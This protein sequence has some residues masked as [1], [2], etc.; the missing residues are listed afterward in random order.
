LLPVVV[1]LSLFL[2]PA[3]AGSATEKDDEDDAMAKY[4]PIIK[5]D[6]I[7]LDTSKAVRVSN[8]PL[9]VEYL[10]LVL[11]D[12]LLYLSEAHEEGA[13][14]LMAYFVGKGR[15]KL[16]PPTEVDR[17]MLDYKVDSETLDTTFTEAF[18][19][20]F[21]GGLASS[22]V[23]RLEPVDASKGR[24]LQE[25]YED[26]R[27]SMSSIPFATP[28]MLGVP[29]RPEWGDQFAVNMKT[30]D[31]GWV[32]YVRDPSLPKENL[33]WKELNLG[34]G[35]TYFDENAENFWGWFEDQ[36]DLDAAARGEM[37]L[38]RD[39][40]DRLQMDHVE[41]DLTIAK[42]SLLVKEK[43]KVTF[44][45]LFDDETFAWFSLIWDNE[46]NHRRTKVLSVKENGEDKAFKH[47]N[48]ILLVGL[49]EPTKAG[50]KRTLELEA[51]FD[52]IRPVTYFGPVPPGASIPPN[53]DWLDQEFQTFT[54]LNTYPWFPQHGFLQRYS[55]DWTIRTPRPIIAV[56][57]GT[58]MKRWEE[59]GYNVLHSKEDEKIALA[60]VLLGKYET[61][62]DEKD[63]RR[64]RIYVHGLHKQRKNLDGMYETARTIIDTYEEKL[65]P[66]PYDELDVGQMGFFFGFGQ[67]PPG[68]VQ[69]T[70]EAFLSDSEIAEFGGNPT[71]KW[72]FYA[73]EIGHEWFG[74]VGSWASVEDQ[75]LSE[76][77]TEYMSGLYLLSLKGFER[78]AFENKKRVWRQRAEMSKDRG[79]ISYGVA[80]GGLHYQNQTYFKG[81]YVL[82]MFHQALIANFDQE[83]GD[84]LFFA[85][86]K[87]FMDKFRHQNATTL[88]FQRVVKDT[89]RLDFDWFFDQW[90]R[91]VGLPTIYWSYDVR[92]TEDGKYLV[93]GTLRQENNAGG[94][95]GLAVPIYLHYGKEVS[96]PIWRVTAMMQSDG[97]FEPVAEYPVKL[98]VP[99]R[100]D[101]VTIDDHKSLLG[102]VVVR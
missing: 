5:G 96:Q 16:V 8:D 9:K 14:P 68:L 50:E 2:V 64:P 41:M 24:G 79:P 87:N 99:R 11:E 51:H 102:D 23:D 12:G 94:P 4:I 21:P 97:K 17:Y 80:N 61:Y 89:T 71:F 30:A 63:E 56:A 81:P 60:S 55:I 40:K 98:K 73:H 52:I 43:A 35:Q 15:M 74:H 42:G 83:E 1:V 90:Y 26:R 38:G 48:N 36:A 10:D 95:K 77:Y 28:T 59:E 33:L 67:A 70:G 32:W 65:G 78:N 86:L 76:S 49:D 72:D 92:E 37:D 47:W 27:E 6:K 13:S 82:H 88:D 93:E 31:H 84:R 45:P 20:V 3:F 57:S 101:R 39:Q 91:G 19:K 25:R 44:T 66:F 46:A 100:P 7:K 22:F 34:F 85:T 18:I 75:W 29:P 53:V 54:L 69:L 58:T 62:T